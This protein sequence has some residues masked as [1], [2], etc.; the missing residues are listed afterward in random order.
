MTVAELEAIIRKA[1]SKDTSDDPEEWTES[2]SARGQCGVTAM[3]IHELFGGVLLVSDVFRDGVRV[4]T[5]YWNRLPSGL[6]VDLTREQFRRGEQFGEPRLIDP[7]T[8]PAPKPDSLRR[9][10]LLSSRVQEALGNQATGL[11][12]R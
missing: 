9:S 7:A 5:H 4:E 2:N 12:L 6:E 11:A 1:W 10:R 3:V 8:S